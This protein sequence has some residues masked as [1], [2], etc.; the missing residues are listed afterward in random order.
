MINHRPSLTQSLGRLCKFSIPPSHPS[1]CLLPSWSLPS[2]LFSYSLHPSFSLLIASLLSLFLLP[3]YL[4][5]HA[6]LLPSF[7]P[8]ASPK[9]LPS[10]RDTMRNHLLSPL[11]EPTVWRRKRLSRRVHC[12][13]LRVLREGF[14]EEVIPMMNS[15]R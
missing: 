11:Q 2:S 13:V 6:F 8:S 4:S 12:G 14:L 7:T 15:D 9:H 10:T 1:S 3:L 5:L